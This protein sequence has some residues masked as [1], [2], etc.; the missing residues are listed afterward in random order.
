MVIQVL[1]PSDSSAPFSFWCRPLIL[2]NINLIESFISPSP[3]SVSLSVYLSILSVCPSVRP[4]ICLS[5][6]LSVC[7]WIWHEKNKQTNK[8]KSP[9]TPLKSLFSTCCFYKCGNQR[10][11]YAQLTLWGWCFS[12]FICLPSKLLAVNLSARS[13]TAPDICSNAGIPSAHL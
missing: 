1:R 8:P 2:M 10:Q 6:C 4:S 13:P 9:G 3:C 11:K 5:V 12:L 7:E